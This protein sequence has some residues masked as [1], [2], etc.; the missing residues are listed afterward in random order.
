MA[1]TTAFDSH[2]AEYEDW[3]VTNKFAFRSELI[4]VKKLLPHIN[5][6]IE[7]GIGSGIFDAPLGIR[8]GVEPSKAMR[9]KSE[10]KGLKALDAV[11]ENLPYADATVNGVIMIT[12]ICFVDDIYQSFNEAYR[13]L[14]KDGFLILDYVDKDNPVGKEYLKH[15][16]EKLFL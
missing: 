16:N 12:S 14:T 15:K 8:E 10:Q 4:A 1:K 11:A 6:V 5:G 13:V 7:I 9:Q 3:F 2:V